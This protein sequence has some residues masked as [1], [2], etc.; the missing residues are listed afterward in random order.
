MQPLKKSQILQKIKL[1]KFGG[2]EKIL[3]FYISLCSVELK[4]TL[5]YQKYILSP[6]CYGVYEYI[7]SG[8]INNRFIIRCA[9]RDRNMPNILDNYDFKYC[10]LKLYE[11]NKGW[12]GLFI[13]TKFAQQ[14][15]MK[16]HKI[17]TDKNR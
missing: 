9:I 3:N 11:R 14:V 6:S 10:E 13:N 17:Y 4:R 15:Y 5:E 7:Y 12:I 2:T 16:L 8:K 1:E